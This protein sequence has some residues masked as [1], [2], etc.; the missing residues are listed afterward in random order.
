MRP[1]S[2][3][4]EAIRQIAANL[5]DARPD[6]WSV[7]YIGLP[8][9]LFAAF[10]REAK[11]RGERPLFLVREKPEKREEDGPSIW[12][13]DGRRVFAKLSVKDSGPNS[14]RGAK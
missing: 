8:T 9:G 13:I 2:E 14:W 6:A 11:A 4:Y 10:Q 1:D 5:R 3:T 12:R 7:F